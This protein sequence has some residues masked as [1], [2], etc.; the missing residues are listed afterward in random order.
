M[1]HLVAVEHPPQPVPGRNRAERLPEVTAD[2]LCGSLSYPLAYRITG[3]LLSQFVS[4][5]HRSI[6]E[7]VYPNIFNFN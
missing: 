1:K 5:T 6:C 2:R 7:H 3:D 4:Y